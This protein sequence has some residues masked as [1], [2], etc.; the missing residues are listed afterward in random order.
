M[1]IEMG[2]DGRYSAVGIGKVTFQRHSGKPF[3]L[4]FFIHVPS[5]KNN[6]VSVAMLEDLGYDVVFSEGK[7]FLRHKA[8]GQVKNIGVRVKKL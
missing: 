1:H 7:A 2:D 5:L 6:L 3:I 8:T 4:K